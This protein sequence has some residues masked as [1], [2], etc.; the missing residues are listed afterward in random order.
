VG[1]GT[2]TFRYKT[3]LSGHLN[4][5]YRT[6]SQTGITDISPNGR[7]IQNHFTCDSFLQTSTV[8]NTWGIWFDSA[9]NDAHQNRIQGSSLWDTS[10]NGKFTE[11]SGTNESLSQGIYRIALRLHE[12]NSFLTLRPR[13]AQL[14]YKIYRIRK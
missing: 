2:P 3:L 5:N 13:G 14:V 12:G 6:V 7:M 10:M 11:H 1:G 8:N 9:P 4:Y